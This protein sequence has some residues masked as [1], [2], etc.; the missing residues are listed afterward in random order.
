MFT[1]IIVAETLWEYPST[2]WLDLSPIPQDETHTW[3]H[4]YAKKLWL[5]RLQRSLL[6][7]EA[8]ATEAKGP[9][10]LIYCYCSAKVTQYESGLLMI[11]YYAHRLMCLSIFIKDISLCSL[12]NT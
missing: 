7:E 1:S 4:Y 11:Y 6:D 12:C 5:Q 3:Y 2:S 10:G 8:V 9:R